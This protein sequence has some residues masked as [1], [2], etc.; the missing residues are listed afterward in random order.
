MTRD[1]DA[2]TCYLMQQ[3]GFWGNFD[4]QHFHTTMHAAC[5]AA[6]PCAAAGVGCLALGEAEHD[7]FN[8]VLTRN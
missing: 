5:T 7:V 6:S 8:D 1:T 4:Q 3:L 2:V